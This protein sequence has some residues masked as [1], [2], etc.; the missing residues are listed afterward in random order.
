MA[1]KATCTVRGVMSRDRAGNADFLR[2]AVGDMA[3][4]ELRATIPDE[5]T[6]VD[7]QFLISGPMPSGR[8]W[9]GQ[10]EILSR[11]Q[12]VRQEVLAEFGLGAKIAEVEAH[13]QHLEQQ[14]TEAQH[15]AGQARRKA[16]ALAGAGK[17]AREM[18]QVALGAD[19]HARTI[20]AALD[21]ATAPDAIRAQLHS[22]L[23]GR[24]RAEA[25]AIRKEVRQRQTL[26][27]QKLAEAAGDLPVLV[28]VEDAL[29]RLV[30]EATPA[31][32]SFFGPT[33]DWLANQLFGLA[34]VAGYQPPRGTLENTAAPIRSAVNY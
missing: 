3:S 34:Q 31:Q 32:K 22:R 1:E 25:E 6:L 33:I 20:A 8:V 24:L 18:E 11:L 7:V 14:L 5:A 4:A 28:A 15:T 30:A 9:A 10:Q 2:F 29:D 27:R 17:D 19:E 26:A 16:A 13:R 23:Q 12:T 21:E